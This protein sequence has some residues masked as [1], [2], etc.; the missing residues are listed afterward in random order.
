MSLDSADREWMTAY[1]EVSIPDDSTK[2][3]FQSGGKDA[4]LN[5]L[6]S[7]RAV[8]RAPSLVAILIV[9]VILQS[10]RIVRPRERKH[11]ENTS[12]LGTEVIRQHAADP[13][14]GKCASFCSIQRE[15]AASWNASA[16]DNWDAPRA[17]LLNRVKHQ[18]RNVVRPK[19]GDH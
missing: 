12:L 7:D 18:A 10:F 3:S 17:C 15:Y 9:E 19:A 8:D 1:P 2:T 6:W 11:E 4:N 5:I 16:D 14:E 13:L